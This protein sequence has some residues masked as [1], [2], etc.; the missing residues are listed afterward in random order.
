MRLGSIAICDSG[1]PLLGQRST[2]KKKISSGN[3]N[4][5]QKTREEKKKRI[6]LDTI[7]GH[8]VLDLS[9]RHLINTS[10]LL[11]IL[12]LYLINVKLRFLL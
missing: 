9:S 1:C 7:I 3:Q 2:K 10:V 5:D 6:D 12:E 11:S 8:K 4:P